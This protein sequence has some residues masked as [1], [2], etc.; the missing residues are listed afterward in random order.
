MA[1]QNTYAHRHTKIKE[2]TTQI[3]TVLSSVQLYY[4][5]LIFKCGNVP[6]KTFSA[7]T[8]PSDFWEKCTSFILC[9]LKAESQA[10]CL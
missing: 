10:Y 1:T 2:L 3:S 9:E 5:H 6:Y 4:P 8:E 7:N